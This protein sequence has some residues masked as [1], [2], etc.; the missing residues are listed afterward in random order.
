[1]GDEV[2]YYAVTLFICFKVLL[3]QELT[4]L[5]IVTERVSFTTC[6]C[7]VAFGQIVTRAASE[8]Q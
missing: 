1:M 7:T 4:L 8:G 3:A 2:Y 5:L 6:R